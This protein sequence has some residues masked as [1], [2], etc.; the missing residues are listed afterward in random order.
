[1]LC[2]NVYQGPCDLDGTIQPKIAY[3]S[4]KV[5]R[6]CP[7][8]SFPLPNGK[9]LPTDASRKNYDICFASQARIYLCANQLID[10]LEQSK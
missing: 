2:F 3:V 5:K 7:I 8:A 1:M 4:G 9:V 6:I 10:P